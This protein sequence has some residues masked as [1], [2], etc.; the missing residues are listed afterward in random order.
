M[1]AVCSEPCAGCG[2]NADCKHGAAKARI[3][4]IDRARNSEQARGGG[5][6]AAAANVPVVGRCPTMCPE[7]E[8]LVRQ[9]QATLHP[10]ERAGTGTGT[11]GGQSTPAKGGPRVCPPSADAAR[12]VKE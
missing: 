5:D 10:F 12:A 11:G 1:L 6:A 4:A 3:K 9:V 7:R 8:V 2:G